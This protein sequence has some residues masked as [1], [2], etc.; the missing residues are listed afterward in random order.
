MFGHYDDQ[1][2]SVWIL[3]WVG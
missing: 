2:S 3:L 1:V